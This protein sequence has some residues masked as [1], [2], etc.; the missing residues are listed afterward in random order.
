MKKSTAFGR[1]QKRGLTPAKSSG[2][3]TFNVHN[4]LLTQ[5]ERDRLGTP[6][7]ASFDA[8]R[9]ARM[10]YDDHMV[11]SSAIAK[12]EI[13]SKK[14]VIRGLEHY[15]EAAQIA[16][17]AIYGRS[18]KV[19]AWTPATLFASEITALYDLVWAYKFCLQHITFREFVDADRLA[20]AQA[21]T[22]GI[23]IVDAGTIATY[24]AA[25]G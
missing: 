19:S 15:F 12:A 6:L 20:V 2:L 23:K 13:L 4:T 3:Q 17:D 11:L 5:A 16:L 10:S 18:A 9:S 24:P 14:K 22:A 21:Q 7:D 8:A 25:A 1:R